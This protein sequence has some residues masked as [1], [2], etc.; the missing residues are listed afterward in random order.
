MVHSSVNTGDL[1]AVQ[2]QVDVFFQIFEQLL[3][4]ALRVM[5][6]QQ[7][8]QQQ[9]IEESLRIWMGSGKDD[10]TLRQVYGRM[11]NGEHRNDMTPERLGVLLNALQQPVTENTDLSQYTR[12]KPAIEVKVDQTTLFRQERDGVVTVNHIQQ[13]QDRLTELNS[14]YKKQQQAPSKNSA[15]VTSPI[16]AAQ[17]QVSVLPFPKLR[18]FLRS[19]LKHGIDSLVVVAQRSHQK[20][21]A[22]AAL[23]AFRQ[24]QVGT[25]ETTYQIGNFS[26]SQQGKNQYLLSDENGILMKFQE[27]RK[28][29][30]MLAV[31]DRLSESDFQSALDQLSQPLLGT[32]EVEYA[33]KVRETEQTVR[34]FLGY[35]Q[36]SV[37]DAERGKFRLELTED[38]RILIFSKQDNRGQVHG[39]P[40]ESARRNHS[41]MTR[42]TQQ[43]F[44]HFAELKHRLVEHQTKRESLNLNQNGQNLNSNGKTSMIELE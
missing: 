42:L 28:G 29:L 39:L 22:Q 24:R 7:Q 37:W 3:Q 8:Q 13:Q 35:M 9:K 21:I 23:E 11:A 20:E 30:Q 10:R 36:T 32:Q 33:F 5:A 12:R 26:I 40:K 31:S 44:E 41:T 38:N 15:I 4:D 6:T 1:E 16:G 14:L 19:V 43:D 2:R 25:N 18:Q 34:D 17:Q 27:S